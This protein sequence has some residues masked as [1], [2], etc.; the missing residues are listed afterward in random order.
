MNEWKDR[1]RK[2]LRDAGK[3][4]VN[5]RGEQKRGKSPPKEVSERT[6]YKVSNLL[7]QSE[8]RVGSCASST[9]VHSYSSLCLTDQ[10]M[11]GSKL[12]L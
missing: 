4:Y 9:T 11:N 10:F 6:V 2:S 7:L 5:R 3:P 12:M 8:G 1:A